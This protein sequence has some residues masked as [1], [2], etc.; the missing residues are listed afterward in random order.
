MAME[1]YD[2]KEKRV[3]DERMRVFER[4]LI[5]RVIDD[6]WKDHLYEMDMLK[7]G[8]HLRA[9]GQKDPLIEYK[10]ESFLMFESLINRIDEKTLNILWKFQV[11]EDPEAQRRRRPAQRLRTVHENA[12]N[13]GYASAEES[14]IQRASRER[15][16]K[17]QPI[18]SAEEKV[19]RN[20]P[21]PCGSGKKYKKCCGAV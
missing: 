10:R 16:D 7:E 17:Q 8:I 6:E 11:Q 1:I 20:D 21:C 9:Y 5:L 12:V 19:G 4:F 3:G 18:R 15:S 2:L 13:L 14:D